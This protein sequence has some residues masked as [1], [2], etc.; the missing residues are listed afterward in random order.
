MAKRPILSVDEYVPPEPAPP[1]GSAP[2]K[3][4]IPDEDETAVATLYCRCSW[5]TAQRLKEL[6]FNKSKN[7][8]KRISVNDLIQQAV[9]EFLE[10]QEKSGG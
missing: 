5:S 9:L 2:A 6:A 4:S 8:R 7:R 1:F 3:V 10:R